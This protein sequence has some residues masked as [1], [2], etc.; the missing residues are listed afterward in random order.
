MK[1]TVSRI[2]SKLLLPLITLLLPLAN[3]SELGLSSMHFPL[4]IPHATGLKGNDLHKTPTTVS[5]LSRNAVPEATISFLNSPYI[6]HHDTSWTK[7]TDTNLIS[8]CGVKISYKQIKD[9]EAA[10][11]VMIDVSAFKK[12]EN[13]VMTDAEVMEIIEKSVALN[14]PKSNIEVIK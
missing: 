1:I 14:F 11:K 2:A 3:A 5:V 13:I 9:G 7:T 12:P 8:L 10:I 4:Y 6:P